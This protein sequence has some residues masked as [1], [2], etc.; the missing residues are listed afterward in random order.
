MITRAE[1]EKLLDAY[2][3]AMS[4]VRYARERLSVAAHSIAV[5]AA[6]VARQKLERAVFPAGSENE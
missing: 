4:H 3:E 2:M 5:D 6:V 1:F